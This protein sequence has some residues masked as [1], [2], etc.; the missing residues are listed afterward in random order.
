MKV[1]CIKIFG[2]QVIKI[3][4]PI[5]PPHVINDIKKQLAIPEGTIELKGCFIE[6]L[7][8]R[9]KQGIIEE[10][11][12]GSIVFRLW[13]DSDFNL[14]FTHASPGTGT[15]TAKVDLGQ[16]FGSEKIHIVFC[17]SPEEIRLHV[18]DAKNTNRH[19]VGMGDKSDF[20]LQ[21]AKDGSVFHLGDKGVEIMGVNFIMK[22]E[23]ILSSTA[24]D[25]WKETIKAIEILHSGTSTEG[26]IFEVVIT[27]L[28]IAM[29][30]TGFETYCKRRFLE[31][32]KEGIVVDFMKLANKFF[33]KQE[34]E[35]GIVEIDIEESKNV[36]VSPCE[37]IVEK[38]RRIDFQNFERCKTAFAKGYGIK[39]G[40]DLG[41]SNTDM[42]KLQKFIKYR[43]RII[44][45]TPLEAMLDCNPSA[46]VFAKKELALEAKGVFDGFINALHSA[47][48]RLRS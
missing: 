27:N 30:V 40:T 4:S 15:R 18:F 21:V 45:V 44:H 24:I 20:R 6:G 12:A 39:F 9:S 37:W 34:R 5:I 26:F 28:T 22:G 11:V 41:I 3:V 47:T 33:S 2:C 17:W 43:H 32:E 38:Y 19:V 14:C 16:L 48:L 7:F 42:E 35:K 23:Q 25:A 31:L 8:D 10:I 36:G 46:P 1:I 13:R 29:L